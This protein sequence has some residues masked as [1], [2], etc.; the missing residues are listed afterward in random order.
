MVISA[1]VHE[2]VFGLIALGTCYWLIIKPW[3]AERR[4]TTDGLLFLSFGFVWWFTDPLGNYGRV[5]YLYSSVTVNLGCPQCYFPGWQ[6]RINSY[7]EPMWGQFFDLGAFVLITLAG[8]RVLGWY[9]RKWPDH[10][11]LRAVLFTFAVLTVFDFFCEVYWLR[12][13]LYVY[14]NMPFALWKNHYYR[15]PLMEV[16][17]TGLYYVGVVCCR[18]FTNDKG[19]TWAERGIS[20]MHVGRKTR[21]ALRVLASIAMYNVALVLCWFIPMGFQSAI[22][23][24]AWPKDLYSRSY[25]VHQICGPTTTY[26]CLD[27]RVPIPAGPRS[28]HISPEG[29]LIAP[30]GLPVQTGK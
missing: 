22:N 28:A 15:V 20:E 8:C 2:I 29:K 4:L 24:T 26:A 9:R 17:F 19:E 23:T 14:P 13:G 12:L 25:L 21:T 3:R 7:A 1:R 11:R 30:Y 10:G 5:A 18:Y 27:P 6:S 16:P